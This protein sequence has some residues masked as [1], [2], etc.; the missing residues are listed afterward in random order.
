MS[1]TAPNSSD[2]RIEADAL[3][4]SLHKR[5]SG[6][7]N[8]RGGCPRS[9]VTPIYARKFGE[10]AASI[11][12]NLVGVESSFDND[13]FRAVTAT[14]LALKAWMTGR[15]AAPCLADRIVDSYLQHSQPYFVAAMLRA[16][17]M[18]LVEFIAVAP[19]HAPAIDA[20][21]RVAGS[22]GFRDL[23]QFYDARV[24]DALTRNAECP[25]PDILAF[26][27]LHERQVR[28][29]AGR[30]QAMR[31]EVWCPGYDFAK[32]Y[33]AQ[34]IVAAQR[35]VHDHGIQQAQPYA[36]EM[37]MIPFDLVRHFTALV[38]RA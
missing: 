15:S 13:Q 12:P 35:L 17:D 16:T 20:L 37:A 5:F 10:H 32:E 31:Y 23:V 36:E 19:E 34:C 24:L 9:G 8:E 29:S 4:A 28:D 3:F 2:P 6:P 30:W 1:D 25:F 22:E 27:N 11:F 26:V 14:I 18:C 7:G 33:H 38:S 21:F